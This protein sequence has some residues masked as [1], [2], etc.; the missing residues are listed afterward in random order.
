MTRKALKGKALIGEYVDCL[1]FGL[2]GG[3]MHRDGMGTLLTTSE[4]LLS[5]Q[6]NPKLN[7]A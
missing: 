1:D 4:C 5:P 6:R 7:K 2:E 3:S